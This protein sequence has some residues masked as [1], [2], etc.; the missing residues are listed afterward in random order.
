MPRVGP[1]RR[2]PEATQALAA[3]TCARCRRSLTY[4]VALRPGTTNIP[5]VEEALAYTGREA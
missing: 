5:T 4:R 2:H 3:V 1:E